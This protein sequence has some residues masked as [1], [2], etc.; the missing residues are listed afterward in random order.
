MG[1]T[2]VGP[3]QSSEQG[4]GLEQQQRTELLKNVQ[5]GSSMELMLRFSQ[6]N[7]DGQAEFNPQDP[8]RSDEEIAKTITED[9]MRERIRVW[10]EFDEFQATNDTKWC[11]KDDWNKLTQEGEEKEKQDIR[12]KIYAENQA[13]AV[14]SQIDQSPDALLGLKALGLDLTVSSIS[15]TA[16]KTM[17]KNFL[18]GKFYNNF[19][20]QDKNSA[21]EILVE[22][23]SEGGLGLPGMPETINGDSLRKQVESLKPFLEKLFG[24]EETFKTLQTLTDLT[25][26]RTNYPDV[27]TEGFLKDVKKEEIAMGMA[28]VQGGRSK[29]D[30]EKILVYLNGALAWEEQ[31]KLRKKWEE[32]QKAK[33]PTA[34]EPP[35]PEPSK[36]TDLSKLS[37]PPPPSGEKEEES[38]PPEAPLTPP[39]DSGRALT[40]STG[41]GK[42]ASGGGTES[43]KDKEDKKE[44][45]EEEIGTITAFTRDTLLWRE[46]DYPFCPSVKIE[47][48]EDY[49]SATLLDPKDPQN[50]GV[51]LVKASK[52]RDHPLFDLLYE[53]DK[54]EGFEGFSEKICQAVARSFVTEYTLNQDPFYQ[55]LHENMNTA[56]RDIFEGKGF[57]GL[58]MAEKIDFGKEVL[59]AWTMLPKESPSQTKL[60]EEPPTAE[61]FVKA[62][63]ERN[64]Y[65]KFPKGTM[66]NGVAAKVS[67]GSSV[68]AEGKTVVNYG[69]CGTGPDEIKIKPDY[70]S[71]FTTVTG[72]IYESQAY[73]MMRSHFV[74]ADP[75]ADAKN[76]VLNICYFQDTYDLDNRSRYT[77]MRVYIEFPKE[78]ADEFLKEIAKNP[79]LLEEF[80]QKAFAGFDSK[81][82]APGAKRVKADGFYLLTGEDLVKFAAITAYSNPTKIFEQLEKH[83][84][85]KGPYGVVDFVY[86]RRY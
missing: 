57:K 43:T 34:P 69:F 78:V 21:Y 44:D 68:D 28:Q 70:E 63:V 23:A 48:K 82:N 85:T 56:I 19:F 24:K 9:I 66:I 58:K 27:F 73:P 54:R 35:K 84:Y 52:F 29:D 53:I 51:S 83:K 30:E 71:R 49:F 3:S 60:K 7:V 22:L 61:K 45:K 26:A 72:G 25:I 31:R 15:D 14:F 74:G 10:E 42:Q 81:N 36:P 62:I 86:P 1:E 6:G 37:V 64:V 67:P 55:T 59:R 39:P 12:L 33:A 38:T 2:S 47:N 75:S 20:S 32:G 76:T 11:K 5:K 17:F 18:R 4:K 41:E 79:D 16:K 40:T 13:E 65:G 8:L 50:K 77:P 80:Y 46:S